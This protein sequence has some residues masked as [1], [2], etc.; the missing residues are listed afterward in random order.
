MIHLRFHHTND[1]Y[2]T[3]PSKYP[4]SDNG[5]EFSDHAHNYVER[6]MVLDDELID[7]VIKEVKK[8]HDGQRISAPF[9]IKWR[10]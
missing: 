5:G 6:R 2:R 3:G 4:P 1:L 7:F 10:R 8:M 9:R